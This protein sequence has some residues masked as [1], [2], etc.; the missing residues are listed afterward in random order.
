M[1]AS[2]EE[3]QRQV[4]SQFCIIRV[5]WN[6]TL[7]RPRSGSG[8]TAHLTMLEYV[9]NLF[10]S[11]FLWAT[12]Q[13]WQL[14]MDAER[15]GCGVSIIIFNNTVIQ[16]SFSPTQCPESLSWPWGW[17][18]RSRILTCST[19]VWRD[20][21]GLSCSQAERWAPAAKDAAWGRLLLRSCCSR[22]FS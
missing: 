22:C 21:L 9:V 13:G 2:F 19:K 6:D 5:Q 15:R 8:T 1:K 17:P 7:E 3:R 10:S 16:Q 14:S 18:A 20:A 4:I 12:P 11:L